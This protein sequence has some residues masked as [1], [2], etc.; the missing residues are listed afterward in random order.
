MPVEDSDNRF[1]PAVNSG[2]R[3]EI[4]SRLARRLLGSLLCHHHARR[5]AN[6][7]RQRCSKI[8]RAASQG[9][10]LSLWWLV[11][12]KFLPSR[13][14]QIGQTT[15]E[16]FFCH[17]FCQTPR[18]QRRTEAWRA[19]HP[20]PFGSV[21]C[22]QRSQCLEG[23]RPDHLGRGSTHAFDGQGAVSVLAIGLM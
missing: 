13:S 17:P 6:N 7:D 10:S 2:A 21:S 16:A 15:L 12:V 9:G 8:R 19:R 5:R 23:S 1:F 14:P 4:A 20:W 3:K 11:C 22:R 18:K